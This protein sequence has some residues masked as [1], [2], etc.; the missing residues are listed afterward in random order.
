MTQKRNGK[1]LCTFARRL[2]TFANQ[3]GTHLAVL[4]STCILYMRACHEDTGV[5]RL[6]FSTLLHGP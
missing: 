1:R 2:I 3:N 6:L 5:M 4:P